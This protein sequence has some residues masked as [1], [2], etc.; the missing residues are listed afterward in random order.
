MDYVILWDLNE[1]GVAKP[2]S[3]MN[4]EEEGGKRIFWN[5]DSPMNSP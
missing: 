2:L 1:P 3:T 5:V 4:D